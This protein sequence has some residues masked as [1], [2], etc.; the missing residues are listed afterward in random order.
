MIELLDKKTKDR[1]IDKLRKLL[2]LPSTTGI[3][4]KINNNEKH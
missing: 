4:Y 2:L 1:I 3:M